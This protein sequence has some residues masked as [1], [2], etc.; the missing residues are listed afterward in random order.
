M[1]NCSNRNRAIPSYSNRHSIHFDVH[2][3]YPITLSTK[4]FFNRHHWM[5]KDK[6]SSYNLGFRQY[7]TDGNAENSNNWFWKSLYHSTTPVTN[8]SLDKLL[9]RRH[10][11]RQFSIRDQQ[12]Q[13]PRII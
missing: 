1:Q 12:Q 11:R 10:Y 13:K 4:R 6:G 8:H 2:N 9:G 7:Y 3:F 5:E